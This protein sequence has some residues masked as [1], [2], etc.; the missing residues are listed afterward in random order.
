M[1]PPLRAL[2][3]VVVVVVT[4]FRC[5]VVGHYANECTSAVFRDQG[6]SRNYRRF[7]TLP[8]FEQRARQRD[9]LNGFATGQNPIDPSRRRS[10]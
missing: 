7:D 6:A 3:V 4:C 9:Y 8:P 5:H 1:P 2:V 10:L